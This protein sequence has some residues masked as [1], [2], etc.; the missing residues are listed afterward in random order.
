MGFVASVARETRTRRNPVPD[1]GRRAIRDVQI[2]DNVHAKFLARISA[3]ALKNY[4][5]RLSPADVGLTDEQLVGI[6]HSQVLSRQVDRM[7]CKLRAANEGYYTVGSSGH[8][9]NAAF[10]EAFRLSDLSFLHYRDAAFQI[11]R[12]KEVAG[13][14]PGWDLLL[15][16]AAS[17]EDPIASGRHKV[18][19]SKLLNIPPQTSTIASHM[20]KAVGAAL[21]IGLAKRI[22]FTET[23]FPADSVVI[24]SFGDASVN[25]STAQGAINSACWNAFQG[26]EVPIAFICEDNGI[27]ISVRTPDG[28]IR[29]QFA[30]RAALR[31][32]P[33]NGLDVLE[34]Y[35]A[36]VA[37]EDFV[38]R[39]RKPVFVH[40]HCVRLQGHAGTDVQTSYRTREEID[41]IE[42]QDPLLHTAATLIG[43]G[44]L[45]GDDVLDTYN[46]VE[47]TLARMADEAVK[48]PKLESPE[49]IMASI[50]PRARETWPQTKVPADVRAAAFA[51]DELLMGKPQHMARLLGW[52]LTDLMLQHENIVIAGEDVGRKGGV[53][54]VTR[55]LQQR[56]GADRVID[57]LLDEQ[58]ILGLGIGLAHNNMLPIAEIQFLAYLHNAEDQ[59][60]GEAAT[61]S[62]FSSRQYSN[63]MIVRVAGLGYQ[64]GF[65][66]HFHNDNSIA[67][68][69]DVPGI[70]IACPSNGRDAVAMMRECVR[71]ALEEKRVVV[72]LEPIARYMTRDL[73]EPGD[74]GWTAVYEALEE[75]SVVA[76]GDVHTEGRGTDLAIVTYGNG[77]Y[78]SRQAQKTLLEIHGV[79][80]RVI[81]MRWLAPLP[82]EALL[83]AVSGCR[84]VLIVDECRRTGSQSES[85]MALF[86]E[87]RPNVHAARIAADDSFIPIGAASTLTLPGRESIVTRALQCI[88]SRG[89]ADC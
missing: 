78:L 29:S 65:G 67:V 84:S 53:Y 36:A 50:V 24:C 74:R 23:N 83:A 68:L 6:F 45:T 62:F 17:S 19:G 85:L 76:L 33:V 79:A 34:T 7:A 63:P 48:R 56:F 21:S 75:G 88:E 80:A 9:C 81:D 60:R 51:E 5:S 54:G 26:I 12:S 41:A 42:N 43:N 59:L 22:E 46:G 40:M 72:F 14:T 52:C 69:R 32:M 10:A 86:A 27:G 87:T 15:S 16:L 11:H 25:H 18:L 1:T 66:G 30:D 20:P 64:Q 82:E 49:E 35:K 44:I 8:E 39:E 13:Q 2:K 73:H 55:K 89:T 70:V 37:A 71:L 61:L 47:E 3:N 31:Y 4:G 38:R 58:S 77:Y 28:W 57:T